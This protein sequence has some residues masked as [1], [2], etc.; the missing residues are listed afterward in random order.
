LGRGTRGTSDQQHGAFLVGQ[1]GATEDV[2]I[3]RQDLVDLIARLQR[4][5]RLLKVVLRIDN[6]AKHK[7]LIYRA[8]KG[9]GTL[10]TKANPRAV[11]E[12]VRIGHEIQRM[13]RALQEM[14]CE[15]R[16]KALVA[17]GWSPA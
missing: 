17:D 2:A 3:G 9:K 11:T 10:R 1:R 6:R 7:N 14:N 4:K 16:G 13:N 12:Y 8:A 5:L 15:R